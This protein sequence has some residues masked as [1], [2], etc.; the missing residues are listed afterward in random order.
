MQSLTLDLLKP[1]LEEQKMERAVPQGNALGGVPDSFRLNP[2][3]CCCVG[4]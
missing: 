2:S 4:F 1:C 3:E